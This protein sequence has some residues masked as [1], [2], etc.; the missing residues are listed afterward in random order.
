MAK[1]GSHRRWQCPGC[2]HK[3]ENGIPVLEVVCH[4]IYGHKSK[5]T[6]AMKPLEENE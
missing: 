1:P 2:G 3:F 4:R 5:A 6:V